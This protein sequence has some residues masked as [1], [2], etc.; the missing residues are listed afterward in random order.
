MPC[1]LS[2]ATTICSA[3]TLAIWDCLHVFRRQTGELPRV[4]DFSSWRQNKRIER[5]LPYNPPKPVA[6]AV[7]LAS[8]EKCLGHGATCCP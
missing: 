1:E 5:Q 8:G 3:S 6:A 4:L 7:C 2:R